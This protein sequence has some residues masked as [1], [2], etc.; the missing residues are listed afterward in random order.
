MQTKWPCMAR[1]CIFP[2]CLA[3]P[4]LSSRKG[5]Y[6]DGVLAALDG[7]PND[8]FLRVPLFGEKPKSLD[9][10]PSDNPKLISRVPVGYKPCKKIL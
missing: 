1:C 3:R 6:L 9:F 5:T 4:I 8:M 2:K 10:E 7:T